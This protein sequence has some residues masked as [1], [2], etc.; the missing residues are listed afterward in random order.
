MTKNSMTAWFK[1]KYEELDKKELPCSYK[2]TLP[3]VLVFAYLLLFPLLQKFLK[4]HI[5]SH[6]FLY[7]PQAYFL[8]AFFLSFLIL[9][10]K[11]N[12]TGITFQG[13]GKQLKTGLLLCLI[14]PA[15][16]IIGIILPVSGYQLLSAGKTTIF[17]GFL[18]GSHFESYYLIQILLLAPIT[19]ELFFRGLLVPPLKR[20]RPLWLVV[21]AASLVFML[22]HGYMKFSAFLLGIFTTVIFIRTGSVIP[23]IMFH[24]SCNAWGPI[25]IY[26][27]PEVYKLIF[28]LFK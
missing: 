27:F 3:I 2:M 11:L 13:L 21:L 22:A 14:P 19:E 4:S 24:M 15:L 20:S 26:F 9:R 8:V 10:F 17:S 1:R 6:K 7:S 18:R 16:V 5:P 28:F 12:E 25:L 23:P